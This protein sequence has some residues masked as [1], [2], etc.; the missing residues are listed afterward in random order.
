M[1]PLLDILKGTDIKNRLD[2]PGEEFDHDPETKFKA[3][4]NYINL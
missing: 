3:K 2:K 1:I 4:R